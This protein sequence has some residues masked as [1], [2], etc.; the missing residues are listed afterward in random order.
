M[1]Q[2][3]LDEAADFAF[4]GVAFR[5]QLGID[6]LAVNGDFVAPPIRR[7]EG[8]GF[9]IFLVQVQQFGG[10]TGRPWGVVS[11]R[12]VFDRDFKQLHRKLRQNGFDNYIR[13][14]WKKWGLFQIFSL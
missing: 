13:R 4:L 6:Q 11:D 2:K 5:G 8:N 9:D 14:R 10:Q 1:S 12:A 7:D 3:L